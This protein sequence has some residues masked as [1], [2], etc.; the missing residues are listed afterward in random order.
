MQTSSFLRKC[1]LTS[2]RRLFSTNL[3]L[4][5]LTAISPIDG[6]YSKQVTDLRPYFSEFALIRY[7]V[8]VELSWYKRLFTEKIVTND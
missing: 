1:L 4:T 8:F 3:G 2:Q 7:R 6:R 5:S